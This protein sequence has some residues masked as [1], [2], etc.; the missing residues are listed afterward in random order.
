MIFKYGEIFLTVP[1]PMPGIF[2]RSSGV[3]NFG[4]LLRRK[5]AM[6]SARVIPIPGNLRKEATEA[7]F[8]SIFSEAALV[9][10]RSTGG[11][12]VNHNRFVLVIVPDRPRQAKMHNPANAIRF[13][14]V[15]RTS[16]F[17]AGGF[18]I[19][20]HFRAGFWSFSAC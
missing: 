6:F 12:F 8:G 13:P 18:I 15:S 9:F 4:L 10:A 5:R 20:F 11:W 17:L 2:V 7:V 3:R 19:S 16:I 1:L 14:L